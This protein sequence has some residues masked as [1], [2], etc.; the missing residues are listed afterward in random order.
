MSKLNSALSSL[1]SFL[2]EIESA[3]KKVIVV[4]RDNCI[5]DTTIR[6]EKILEELALK[7]VPKSGKARG[8]FLKFWSEGKYSSFD[9]VNDQ[10]IESIRSDY[11]KT[12]A[13]V[14]VITGTVPAHDYA[15]KLL[16]DPIEQ[17]FSQVN[18]PVEAI[19]VRK[20]EDLNYVDPSISTSSVASFKVRIVRSKYIPIAVYD[21]H[22]KIVEAFQR[23][24]HLPEKKS[25]QIRDYQ[26]HKVSE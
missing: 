20:F 2:T 14:V 4:D 1:E 3:L 25:F 17:I 16:I 22:L 9:K 23:A 21:D 15:R 6:R 7:E 13:P 11:E 26:V 5:Y 18:V 19:Y 12:K 24:F 10:I 8:V